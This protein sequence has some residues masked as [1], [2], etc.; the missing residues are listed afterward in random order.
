VEN[1]ITRVQE[2]KLKPDAAW[3]E[4]VKEAEKASKA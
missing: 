4:A 3:A 1:V 2:G